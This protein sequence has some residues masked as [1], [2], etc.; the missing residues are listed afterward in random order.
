[1]IGWFVSNQDNKLDNF[2]NYKIALVCSLSYLAIVRLQCLRH[3]PFLSYPMI[4]RLSSAYM[5]A[6]PLMH[7]RD[8][9]Q[10]KWG[11]LCPNRA[12]TCG[13]LADERGG[14]MV[15]VEGE[16]MGKIVQKRSHYQGR[17]SLISHIAP[18]KIIPH[19]LIKMLLGWFIQRY[20]TRNER[21]INGR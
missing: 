16:R 5:Q 1:M 7:I 2:S 14:V 9:M 11:G 4:A 12:C 13:D 10:I 6:P 3:S 17:I 21:V 18:D 15:E 19:T 8:L 20:Y